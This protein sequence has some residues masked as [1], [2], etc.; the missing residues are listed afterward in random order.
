MRHGTDNG[1]SNGGCR[2]PE[3]RRAHA[4]ARR[5]REHRSG[6]A[7][8]WD[9]YLLHRDNGGINGRGRM[10]SVRDMVERKLDGIE[11]SVQDLRD[12]LDK[13]DLGKLGAAADSISEQADQLAQRF[14]AIGDVVGDGDEEGEEVEDGAKKGA[15]KANG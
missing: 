1:Y 10:T 7:Y 2:C 15:K 14:Q 3:C 6:R 9:V 5:A 11:G 12:E 13:G 4:A 8:P